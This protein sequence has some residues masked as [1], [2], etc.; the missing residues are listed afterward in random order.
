MFPSVAVSWRLNQPNGNNGIQCCPSFSGHQKI[1]RLIAFIDQP[2][3]LARKQ[4][5]NHSQIQP[6]F[7]GANAGDVGDPDFVGFAFLRRKPFL[8]LLYKP[9]QRLRS[10]SQ[11]IAFSN[12]HS[13]CRIIYKPL[14]L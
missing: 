6:A 13:S 14:N 10:S 1:N 11:F 8:S 2:N 12:L 3:D 5:Q 7:I 9:E 4:I